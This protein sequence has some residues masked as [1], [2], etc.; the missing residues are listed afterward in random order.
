MTGRL[1]VENDDDIEA[2]VG[3]IEQYLRQRRNPLIDRKDFHDRNQEE[4][5]SVGHYVAAL[6]QID[7]RCTHEDMTCHSCRQPA[8]LTAELRAVRLRDRLICGLRNRDMQHRVLM[9]TYDTDLT[10]DRV[11]QLCRAYETSKE[12]EAQLNPTNDQDFTLSRLSNYKKGDV[13]NQ[14]CPSPSQPGLGTSCSF[15]GHG[16]HPRPQCPACKRACRKCG[17]T[18]HFEVL[19]RSQGTEKEQRSSGKPTEAKHGMTGHLYLRRAADCQCCLVD[20]AVQPDDALETKTVA[21]LPDTG[22]DVDAIRLDGLHAIDPYLE[23]N[24]ADNSDD[25]LAPNEERRWPST[26][27]H[28]RQPSTF[29]ATWQCHY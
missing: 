5:E 3:K 29:T 10:L 14:S 23:Y 7:D 13:R 21:W 25:V 8:G 1:G 28:S 2:V 19:C 11:V 27:F 26:T 9:E 20:L 6:V 15:C 24:L 17:K 18:G 16:R 4:G 12:T 22:A